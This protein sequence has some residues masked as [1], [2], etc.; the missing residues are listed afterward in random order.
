LNN[1][2]P[3][4]DERTKSHLD[5]VARASVEETL[6]ALPTLADRTGS[7]TRGDLYRKIMTPPQPQREHI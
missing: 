4:D 3:I 7:S 2:I 1:V 5:R 6:N